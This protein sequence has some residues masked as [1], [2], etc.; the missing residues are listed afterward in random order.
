MDAHKVAVQIAIKDEFLGCFRKANAQPGDMLSVE[1]LY[2][3]FLPSLSAKEQQA[4][5]E[6]INEMLT[7]GMI[8]YVDGPKVTYALTKKGKEMIC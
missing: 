6:T 1:W 2:N 7:E 3:D 5:E 8:K 4:L